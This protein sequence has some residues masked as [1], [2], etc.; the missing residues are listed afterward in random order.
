MNKSSSKTS[1]KDDI[2]CYT[3]IDAKTSG[4]HT[5]SE[6]LGFRVCN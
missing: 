3:G 5:N 4:I 6:V 1:A 2:I